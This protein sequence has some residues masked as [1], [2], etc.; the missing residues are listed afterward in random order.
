MYGPTETTVWSTF[1][2]LCYGDVVQDAAVESIGRPIANTEV[3]ILD[4]HLRPVPIGV[5][6]DLYIGGDGLAVGY[7][8]LRELTAQR[9]L[10][11][12]FSGDPNRRL[13]KTGD[14]ARYRDNG[15]I[16]YLGRAD[17]QVKVRGFRIEL[18]EIEAVL[19]THPDVQQAIADAR[20]SRTGDKRLIVWYVSSHSRELSPVGLREHLKLKLPDYMIPALFVAVSALPMTPNGKV[21]RKALAEPDQGYSQAAAYQ[22]P[23]TE[24]EQTL[25]HLWEQVLNVSRIG[26]H[27]D[28]FEL[29]GQSLKATAFIARLQ[30]ETGVHL[31]LV[32][33]FRHPSV[34]ALAAHS[35]E[36]FEGRSPIIG[37][38]EPVF[39][40]GQGDEGISP[41]TDEE[42]E[43]LER[44]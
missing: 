20:V 13:Y 17:Q 2:K 19:A 8:N 9:F 31:T 34:A 32:D 25:A 14:N 12:P 28:F 21:D 39:P 16:E 1:R 29:G 5:P 4:R 11:H 35:M 40:I 26:I 41:A 30:R 6:G 27:D 22:E 18:G 36:S 15:D 24:W 10:P 42:L 33:I 7:R 43:M 38:A 44:L 23:Q 3:Y 37:S